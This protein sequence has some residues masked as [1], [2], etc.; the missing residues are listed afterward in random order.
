MWSNRRKDCP[1]CRN[2]VT[3]VSKATTAEAIVQ[4]LIERYQ[5]LKRSDYMLG[6]LDQANTFK[7][8]DH[9]PIEPQKDKTKKE[10]DE[11]NVNETV[12]VLDENVV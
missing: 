12:K 4:T 8:A 11:E 6:M 10:N 2:T 7:G 5:N 1:Q 9:F 3:M